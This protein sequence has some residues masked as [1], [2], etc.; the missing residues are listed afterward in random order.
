[1]R[2]NDP[3]PDVVSDTEQRHNVV[4]FL[5]RVLALANDDGSLRFVKV[6]PAQPHDFT[7][8]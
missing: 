3:L 8:S 6:N 1:M 4:M 2:Q 5:L 7:L